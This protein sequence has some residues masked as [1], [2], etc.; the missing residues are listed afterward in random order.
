[1]AFGG[2]EKDRGSLKYRC[3]AKHYGL[4]CA[5]REQCWISDSIRIDIESN[6]RIF[7]PLARSSYKWQTMY[8]KRSAV[9]RVNSRLDESFG[10]EKHYIRGMNKME[11]R[12]GL[13]LIV[14]LG[15][16]YGRAR[17]KQYER[18]RSLVTSVA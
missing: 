2:F 9:E 6:R 4:D 15:M 3:P 16:A 8:N 17:Q 11:A 13:A 1:M 10:F 12:C 14:M 5:D 7:T 18:M